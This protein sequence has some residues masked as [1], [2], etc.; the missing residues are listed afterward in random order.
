MILKLRPFKL[1]NKKNQSLPSKQASYKTCISLIKQKLAKLSYNFAGALAYAELGTVV[2]RSGS[3]YAYFMESF[4]TLHPFWGRLPAF[5]YSFVMVVIIRP[6]EVAI[7]ILTFSEYLCQPI[8]DYLCFHE[9]DL[10]A[11]VKKLVA[12]VAL[13]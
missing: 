3:E 4:S 9:P 1:N 2:Q 7:I 5:L 11:K 8:L 6:A 10:S 13:G 12:L